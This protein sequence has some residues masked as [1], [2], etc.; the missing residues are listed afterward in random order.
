MKS[1]EDL[2]SDC[3]AH[4][5]AQSDA[6][7]LAI[8]LWKCGSLSLHAKLA[9]CVTSID[10]SGIQRFSTSR[11]PRCLSRFN[12]L[13]HLSIS[14]QGSLKPSSYML[15]AEIWT[16]SSQLQS[17]SIHSSDAIL[18]P[19]ELNNAPDDG[20]FAGKNI[21]LNLR[22][23]SLTVLFDNFLQSP[24]VSSFAESIR[25][26]H[27]TQDIFD[28]SQAKLPPSLEYL[29]ATVELS[30]YES[31]KRFFESLPVTLHHVHNIRIVEGDEE[32]IKALPRHL[33]VDSFEFLAT[34]SYDS[35]QLCPSGIE[36][37][38][39][40]NIDFDSFESAQ[41]H[42]TT[43]LPQQLQ[44]LVLG[45]SMSYDESSL[46]RLPTSI[47]ELIACLDDSVSLAGEKTIFSRFPKLA[48]LTIDRPSD[49]NF[50][51]PLPESLTSLSGSPT[52]QVAVLTPQQFH[53]L[54][55]KLQYLHINWVIRNNVF[56]SRDEMRLPSTLRTLIVDSWHENWLDTLP[57]ALTHL[58]IVKLDMP[59]REHFDPNVDYFH[60]APSALRV[61]IVTVSNVSYQNLSG[62]SFSQLSHLTTL[63][64]GHFG[65][66]HP[67]IL[68]TLNE[69]LPRLRSVDISLN[70]RPNAFMASAPQHLNFFNLRTYV[71]EECAAY[72]PLGA[73][74]PSLI[75]L[76][77]EPRVAAA[78]ARSLQYPDPR[79]IVHL[80]K[81]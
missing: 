27:V 42:W 46:I 55:S 16:L 26:L 23:L 20:H 30:D 56:I 7:F 35:S 47:T 1:L 33:K 51:H 6:S 39:L 70:D 43:N 41:S 22:R 8:A 67:S 64:V 71:T 68:V 4:I 66:F 15:S 36:S 32:V 79:A 10:L 76:A 19:F 13:R 31:A 69:K 59:P 48:S 44:S 65:G 34:W 24:L 57:K 54:P 21:F 74:P 72:W 73:T 62:S 52:P 2:S 38:E 80:I 28:T 18:R 60:Y 81:A 5:L 50:R 63:S 14:L 61:L 40:Q 75:K 11:W 3:L 9:T 53:L 29:N 77:V 45:D 78:K 49:L 37:L 58:K 25:E 12:H 17:L